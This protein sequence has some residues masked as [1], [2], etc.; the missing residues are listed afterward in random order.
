LLNKIGTLFII[1]FSVVF[2]QSNFFLQPSFYFTYGDYSDKTNSKQYSFF[3]SFSWNNYD[4]V[5]LG[6]D[7]INISNRSHNY[8]WD[9]SQNNFSGGLHLWLSELKMKLKLDFL[10]IDGNY[11][12]DY[13]NQPVID[14]G[15]LISPEIIKGVY[16]FYYGA[17][18]SF[19]KQD[20]NNKLQAHQVYLRTDYYPH[21]KILLNTILSSH[22]VSD[23]R[24]QLSLQIS[25]FYFPI[26]ELSIKGSFTLGKRS[27]FYHPDLMVLYNQ[28]ETQTANYSIQLNYNFYKNFVM[29]FQYQRS[30]FTSYQINYFVLGIK[31][32]VYF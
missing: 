21:Y 14:N 19:F 13:S 20:G 1:S 18:Y 31:S 24:K 4:Y 8:K 26:Y 27:I 32:P 12:D 22:L 23:N 16:P 29:S 25:A 5:V 2:A 11:K 30:N 6:Y 15:Y 28:L 3:T 17:G 9:Y 10:T 7:R